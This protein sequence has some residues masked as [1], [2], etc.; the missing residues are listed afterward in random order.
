MNLRMGMHKKLLRKYLEEEL[1]LY[2][3]NVVVYRQ[4]DGSS[5]C[6][7]QSSVTTLNRPAGYTHT[8]YFNFMEQYK[9]TGRNI[10]CSPHFCPKM[11]VI[12]LNFLFSRLLTERT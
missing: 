4:T 7:L 6:P 10:L 9:V 2:L 5:C 1:A 12:Q 8:E 3:Y 11:K